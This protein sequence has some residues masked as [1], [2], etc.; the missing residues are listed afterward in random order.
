[1]TLSPKF[2]TEFPRTPSRC[3]P[4]P[5]I[6]LATSSGSCSRGARFI[7][8]KRAPPRAA[9]GLGRS[10]ILAALA[11]AILLLIAVGGITWEAI[12][13]FSDPGEVAGKTV[14]IVAALGIVINGVTALLFVR[15]QGSDL[16]I[17]AA[18]LHM[19]SD[20]VV[21]AGVVIA[22]L[23]IIA[24]G[25]HWV[26]P[27]TSLAINAVIVWGTWACC[28]TLSAWRSILFPRMS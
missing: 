15:G 19:A 12:R 20:A 21:S 7:S 23:I 24:T 4:T 9:Y 27:V 8:E 10:S 14:I 17:K 16:N 6:T 3:W 25:W 28:V 2:F 26:D 22:G 13:R 18:F 11:N 1:F 5:D